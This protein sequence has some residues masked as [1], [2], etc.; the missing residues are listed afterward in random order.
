MS[1]FLPPTNTGGMRKTIGI[2]VVVDEPVDSVFHELDIEIEQETDAA[3]AEFQVSQDLGDMN[4]FQSRDGF[5]LPDN[6][7]SNFFRAFHVPRRCT[8]LFGS[9]RACG[10]AGRLN[11]ARSHGPAGR[12]E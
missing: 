10:R 11:S 5:E 4:R 6:Q 12:R 2:R 8:L 1:F 9:A 7:I 3:A